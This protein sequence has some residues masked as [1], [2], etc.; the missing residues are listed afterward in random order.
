[1][2]I[3]LVVMKCLEQF[4]FILYSREFLFDFNKMDYSIYRYKELINKY[5]NIIYAAMSLYALNG[6]ILIII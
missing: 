3:H 2:L 5:P 1:M 4:D 6:L